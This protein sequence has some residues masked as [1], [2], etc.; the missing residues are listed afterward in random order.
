M[1]KESVNKSN[2]KLCIRRALIRATVNAESVRP[3]FCYTRKRVSSRRTTTRILRES[4]ERRLVNYITRSM[5]TVKIVV[6]WEIFPTF[7]KD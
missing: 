4:G 3:I 1:G 5:L 7:T 6:R 2:H